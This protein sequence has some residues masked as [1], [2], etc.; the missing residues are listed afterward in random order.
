LTH[1]VL[2]LNKEANALEGFLIMQ[3]QNCTNIAVIDEYYSLQGMLFDYQISVAEG[4]L[5]TLLLPILE[6]IEIASKEKSTELDE[7]VVSESVVVGDCANL[8]VWNRGHNLYVIDEDDQVFGMVTLDGMCNAIQTFLHPPMLIDDDPIHL[9]SDSNNDGTACVVGTVDSSD[10]NN[11]D[12]NHSD[13]NSTNIQNNTNTKKRKREQEGS[14]G[15]GEEPK[16]NTKKARYAKRTK[17]N[18]NNKNNNGDTCVGDKDL[19]NNDCPQQT[20]VEN[21]N[22]STETLC[23][24]NVMVQ[25]KPRIAKRRNKPNNPLLLE[26]MTKQ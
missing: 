15:S 26:N 7:L 18:N 2:S 13:K 3:R 12:D 5:E 17:K 1:N 4:Q 8:L 6:F 19:N 24:L 16:T 21:L 25:S 9:G 11:I 20:N 22:N 14:G 10:S 23:T